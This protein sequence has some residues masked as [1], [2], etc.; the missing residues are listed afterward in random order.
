M[1]IWKGV[2]TGFYVNSTQLPTHAYTCACVCIRFHRPNIQYWPPHYILTLNNQGWLKHSRTYVIAGLTGVSPS[3]SWCNRFK[4]KHASHWKRTPVAP[5]NKAIS[6]PL[7]TWRR[8]TICSAHKAY[9][10]PCQHCLVWW[11]FYNGW[12]NWKEREGGKDTNRQRQTDKQTD[13]QKGKKTNTETE[14]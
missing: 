2:L 13:T 3:I 4:V 8:V 7:H 14:K 9:I 1:Q 11:D 10:T 6:D 12:N 5:I